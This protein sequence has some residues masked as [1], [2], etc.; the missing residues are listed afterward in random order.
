MKLRMK[1]RMKQNKE[2]HVKRGY[3]VI[4][5]ASSGIGA[6]FARQLAREGFSLIL[7]ARRRQKLEELA[8]ELKDM[9]KG[10]LSGTAPSK[11]GKTSEHGCRENLIYTADLSKEQ[12]CRALLDW[13]SDKPVTMFVNNAG[14][15]DAG[16]LTEL[17]EEKALRMIDVNVKAVQILS[18]EMLIR[19]KKQGFGYLMNVASSAGLLPA[20][21]YMATYYASKAYVASLT[22]AI[23]RETKEEGSRVYIGCLCPGPVDT[24]FNE[25]ANVEFALPGITAESCVRECIRGMKKRR[26]VIVP[27]LTMQAAVTFGRFLPQELLIAITGH[28]QKSKI[29]LDI[30]ASKSYHDKEQ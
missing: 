19:F 9:R 10:Q 3:A 15:G 8:A 1:L 22:R 11:G 2:K 16:R 29:S 26:T 24:G 5:G 25:A 20:G 23:A 17:D 7:V 14:F 4:T 27:T 30:N 12:E 21:P 13:L 28:Q 18:R 6:E